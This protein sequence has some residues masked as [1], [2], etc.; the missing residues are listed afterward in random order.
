M[1]DIILE[2][3]RENGQKGP[4]RL[5]KSCFAFENPTDQSSTTLLHWE[6]VWNFCWS[7]TN[8]TPNVALII[9]FPILKHPIFV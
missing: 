3:L 1:R 7:E 8:N 6:F 9:I 2:L 5:P 4:F